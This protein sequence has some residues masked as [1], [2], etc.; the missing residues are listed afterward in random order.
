VRVL[1]ALL[2]ACAGLLNS[3]PQPVGAASLPAHVRVVAPNGSTNKYTCGQ[4]FDTVTGWSDPCDLQTALARARED[5]T[6]KEIWVKTGTYTPHNSDVNVSF[7]IRPGL[8]VFGGFRGNETARVQRTFANLND[9]MTLLS[10]KLAASPLQSKQVVT[11]I[12]EPANQTDVTVLDRLFIA[13]GNGNG[14]NGAGLYIRNSN[15]YISSSRISNNVASQNGGGLYATGS[16]VTIVFSQILNNNSGSNGGGIAA[17][18]SNI[19]LA[20]TIFMGNQSFSSGKGV[21]SGNGGRFTIVN[22]IFYGNP[23]DGYPIALFSNGNNTSVEIETSIVQGG[24]DPEQR[25]LQ[26]GS[27][28]NTTANPGIVTTVGPDGNLGTADDL[29][30]LPDSPFNTI[31]TS[32]NTPADPYDINDDKTTTSY[33]YTMNGGPVVPTAVTVYDF[34]ATPEADGILLT[35]ET[36]TE[37]DNLGFNLYRRAAGSAEFVLLNPHLIESQSPGSLLGAAY[38]FFDPADSGMSYTYRLQALDA[39]GSLQ[40]FDLAYQPSTSASCDFRPR[41]FL[42]I[43]TGR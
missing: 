1:L 27:T 37:I 34:S 6:I 7:S 8:W 29:I 30:Y 5:P 21:F 22:S 11:V 39:N 32:Q 24:C 17:V 36:A 40:S 14:N 43:I 2:F 31:S 12:A 23:G 35:W 25:N 10:G 42:P 4:T 18:S 15:V 16:K 3:Q 13:N 38:S 41:I 20:N 19:V 28:V 33:P 26:C 9:Q